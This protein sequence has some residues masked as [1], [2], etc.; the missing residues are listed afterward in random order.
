[1]EHALLTPVLG[2]GVYL[3]IQDTAD[4]GFKSFPVDDL[5][6]LDDPCCVAGK[7]T[8]QALMFAEPSFSGSL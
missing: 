8:R 4:Q 1:M 6:S 3:A 7:P 5:P 2:G